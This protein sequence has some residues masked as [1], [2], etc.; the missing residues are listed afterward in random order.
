MSL[1][2]HKLTLYTSMALAS[3]SSQDSITMQFR[4]HV[5]LSML[6]KDNANWAT[7]LALKCMS[8]LF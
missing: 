7:A 4:D 6:G 8:L 3:T 5:T 2:E 1:S